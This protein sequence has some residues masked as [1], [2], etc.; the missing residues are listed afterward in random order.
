LTSSI[1]PLMEVWPNS[2]GMV[3]GWSPTKIVKMVLIG[4]ISRSWG[5][6]IG[7]QN[8]IFKDL[9]VYENLKGPELSYL[10]YNIIYRSSTK[11]VQI[12]SLVLKL[13]PPQGHNFTLNYIR[14]TSN[15]V[16]YWTTLMGNVKLTSSLEPLMGIWPNS[17]RMIPG[18]LLK[19]LKWFWLVAR[20]NVQIMPLV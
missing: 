2:T 16:F 6:K 8:A 5:H 17:T 1:E 9:L 18:P 11:V 4:C 3:P 20:K 10:V 14:K 15:N 19:L 7:F 13:T 12:M